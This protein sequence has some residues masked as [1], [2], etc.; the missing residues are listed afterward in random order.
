MTSLAEPLWRHTLRPQ[1]GMSI[2]TREERN[3][4]VF[5]FQDG[6]SRTFKAGFYHLLEVVQDL[7]EDAVAIVDRLRK[8][9]EVTA[10]RREL[11][12]EA[13]A[14]GKTLFTFDQQIDVF[15]MEYPG[16]FQ[17]E[18]WLASIRGAEQPRR[19]K[20]H[21]NPAVVQAREELAQSDLDA[22]IEASDWELVNQR[23]ISVLKATELVDPSKDVKFFVAATEERPEPVAKATR[24]LIYGEGPLA[25]RMNAWVDAVTLK[26]D[27]KPSWRLATALPALIDPDGRIAVRPS[28]FRQQAKWFMPTLR[29][30]AAPDGKSYDAMHRLA[31]QIFETLVER[32]LAPT[33][34]LDIHDFV[35]LT[36]R[37]SA[38]KK[39]GL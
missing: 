23:A 3:R 37:P 27:S 12:Q 18:G 2:L 15:R 14:Q 25:D 24:N 4:R 39:L 5:Q 38:R 26:R 34:Y 7:P 21:R 1:W 11:Q 16:G 13:T 29:W 9:Q 36:L 30:Q 31:A 10:A 17:D 20:V 22:A 19:R 8:S 33:D 32:H 28:V 6:K 35:R